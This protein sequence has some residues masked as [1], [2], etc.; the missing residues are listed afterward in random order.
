MRKSLP[1]VENCLNC[2]EA[3]QENFCPKCGQETTNRTTSLRPLFADLL[4]EVFSFDSKL[5][6]TI[7]PLFLRPGQ[8]TLDYNLGKRA[9][10]L[11][12]FKI[13][14]FMSLAF[15]LALTWQVSSN[16]SQAVQLNLPAAKG[17]AWKRSKSVKIAFTGVTMDAENLPPSVEAYDAW[18]KDPANTHKN[19]PF[20]QFITRK[21]LRVAKN[22]QGFSGE[23][24]NSVPKAMFFLLPLFALLLKIIYI[25][26]KR[27]YVEHLVFSLHVHAFAF[28]ML[29]LMLA[30]PL[31]ALVPFLVL[32]VALYLFLAMKRVYGQGVFK[33]CLKIGLLGFSY[34]FLMVFSVIVAGLLAILSF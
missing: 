6:H 16:Q 30:P 25:R 23:F 8:L 12:P 15:F 4:A 21:T 22:P 17:D 5:L 32:W 34:L 11:S 18:Q 31:K 19:T 33:T 26:S 13:Y 9:R 10:Y 29:L 7:V 24:I 1:K 2:G 28:G 20:E 3:V 14:L 27:F